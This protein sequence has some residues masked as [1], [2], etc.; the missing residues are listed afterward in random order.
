MT[1]AANFLASKCPGSKLPNKGT[2]TG[3]YEGVKVIAHVNGG[4]ITSIYPD[5][6]SQPRKK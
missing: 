1:A 5:A 4:E 2:L 6:K 3:T